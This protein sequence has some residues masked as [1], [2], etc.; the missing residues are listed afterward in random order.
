MKYHLCPGDSGKCQVLLPAGTR[1]CPDHTG[2]PRQ[3]QTVEATG[4]PGG[5]F[6]YCSM[7]ACP[8]E[9]VRRGRCREHQSEEERSYSA[10]NRLK[11]DGFYDSQGWKIQRTL[12]IVR[13][14]Y[15][16]CLCGQPATDVDHITSIEDGGSKL[17]LDNLQSLC[18]AC[19]SSKTR[20][21]QLSR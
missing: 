3:Q 16:C 17:A 4:S 20:S 1:R 8:N 15:T 7:P 10:R 13:D 19:H 5:K 9:A 12:A 18:R 6:V 11:R 2:R 14:H 21:E